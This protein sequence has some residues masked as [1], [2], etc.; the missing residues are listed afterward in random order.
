MLATRRLLLGGGQ[1]PANTVP[2]VITPSAPSNTA[3]PTV[4]GTAQQGQVLTATTG[5]WTNSPTS[6]AYQWQTS[7]N[8][9]SG[10]A[11]LTGATSSTYTA[12][13]GDVGNYLRVQVTATNAGGS[14]AASSAATSQVTAGSLTYQQMVAALPASNYWRANETSGTTLADSIGSDAIT[15]LTTP[16]TDF[17]VGQAGPAGTGDTWVQFTGTGEAEI[18]STLAVPVGPFSAQA[19]FKTSQ[20]GGIMA[21]GTAQTGG[22]ANVAVYV[23]SDGK[24]YFGIWNG[25][26]LPVLTS[27]A[28]VND[29]VEHL[30]TIVLLANGNMQL[31]VDLAAVVSNGNTAGVSS[32]AGFWQFGKVP[33]VSTYT[34]GTNQNL[35]GFM[36]EI[37]LC[38]GA[39]VTSAQHQA[40][41]NK[42]A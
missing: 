8:G 32:A 1:I 10:W 31:M 14:N 19:W 42:G 17:N 6:Y 27:A 21:Y 36:G 38:Y 23:G 37:D 12:Q 34:N 24:L 20:A 16:G 15:L 13:A 7:A 35:T 40:L 9:T 3:V 4:S 2:P 33:A 29:G 11:N 28:A 22:T 26:T 41:Y 30:L 39:A 5:T 18:A 25:S